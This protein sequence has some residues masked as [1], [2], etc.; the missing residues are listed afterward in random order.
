MSFGAGR[1]ALVVGAHPDDA[2]FGCY[3]VLQRC[4]VREV[5]VLTAGE[6]GGPP[7]QRR[8]EA[9]RAAAVVGAEITVADQP[10]T[11][12]A[13]GPAIAA[14]SEALARV[15]PDV[16]FAPSRHDDHQDHAVAAHAAYV[17]TRAW[18]GLLV[19]YL[20][21]SAVPRFRPQLVV[22]LDDAE[23]ERKRRAL[24]AHASQAERSYLSEE[25]LTSTARHWALH[26]APGSRWAEPFEIVRW[27]VGPPR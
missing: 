6:R 17:A 13:A 5:L 10:D 4:A 19:A 27:L 11:A 24:A 16:V 18:P 9:G 23:W 26:G 25:Y 20:T 8:Q 22:G 1:R 3:G 7:G 15:A 14:V 2:E 21:P 12:L